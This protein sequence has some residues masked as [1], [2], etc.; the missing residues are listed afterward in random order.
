MLSGKRWLNLVLFIL[1]ILS[2]YFVGYLWGI[3]YL[4]AGQNPDEISGALNLSLFLEP[5]LIKLSL[6]Y[7][8]SLLVI[9]LGHELG[10]YLTCRRYR[11]QASLPFFIPAPTLIGTLG[12][13]IRI[14]SPLTRREE[15]FD[16]GANG[17]ITGFL[18]SVPALFAGLQLSRLIPALPRESSIL[19][20]EPLLLKLFVRLTF[21]PV[22]QNQDLILH[23]LA[24][25][26]WVGLLVTSF[27]L[28]PVG[29]LDGGHILYALFGEKI[30]KLA[31][32]IILILLVLGIFYWAGWLIWAVLISVMGLRHPPVAASGQGFSRR[33]I[34]L[35]LAVALIF[36]L[37]FIPA[38]ISGNSLLDLLK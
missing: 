24:V 10:H 26:G 2:T 11:V 16:V 37:S 30:R 27:N 5:A 8:L 13:F 21:G 29:Q 1:T 36:I 38:P 7:S 6:V 22:A 9:L 20:G 23:P 17:P 12:A 3:N 28:F 15:L 34:F 32:G 18:L 31:P 25:A 14:K 4:F 19:F 33:R 35:S